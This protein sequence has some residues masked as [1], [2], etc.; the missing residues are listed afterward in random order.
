M[1]TPPMRAVR[2]LAVSSDKQAKDDKDS[3]EEQDRVTAAWC[4]DNG[5]RIVD[6]LRI[7][8]FS[9]NW[10]DWWE[11]EQ[12][13]GEEG[14]TAPGQL[15]QHW[16][17]ADFDVLVYYD[18]SRIGRD[19]PLFSYIVRRTILMPG[20]LASIK[21]WG[22][23][24][25]NNHRAYIAMV[26]MMASSHIDRLNAYREFGQRNRFE[27]NKTTTGHVP[28]S[29]RILRDE[30]GKWAG[31][32]VREEMRPFLDALAKT[33]LGNP[34]LH[35]RIGF[36]GIPL[37]LWEHYGI[38]PADKRMYPVPSIYR[39]V[40]NPLFW[41]HLTLNRLKG[42]KVYRPIEPWVYDDSLQPP[43][44]IEIKRYAYPAAYEGELADALKQELLRRIDTSKGSAGS[45]PHIFSGLVI[46]AGC[47]YTLPWHKDGA[48][49]CR[50]HY[51]YRINHCSHDCEFPVNTIKEARLIEFITPYLHEMLA[52]KNALLFTEPR[53]D[54]VT[55]D[56][57][58]L[59]AELVK[60]EAALRNLMLQ[61][62]SYDA[63][64]L[65]IH[66][67]AVSETAA[68]IEHLKALIER[69]KQQQLPPE[70]QFAAA[71]SAYNRVAL[72]PT[73]D[74]LW[75]L[76][77]GDAQAILHAL[78]GE[79]RLIVSPGGQVELMKRAT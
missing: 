23:V 22:I 57:V 74:D 14:I 50:T 16:E 66:D 19:Q 42:R 37:A 77:A 2:L 44:G 8:G 55:P 35:D 32:E 72:L 52:T 40:S 25:S 17:R 58:V 18:G 51:R 21:D 27:N 29:H 79:T 39:L 9:R 5:A 71:F 76:P 41:G 56:P 6:T 75:T 60:A 38:K 1:T 78:L 63:A 15:R 20:K 36:Q 13:A 4:K 48:F 64:V 28:A 11:F 47:N 49:R 43:D 30:R 24:D 53:L 61:R 62:A 26:G 7:P 33:L 67:E 3:L 69:S 45:N 31:V 34:P 12:A 59:E 65:Y 70:R 46:C 73:I 10:L 54:V 68:Q